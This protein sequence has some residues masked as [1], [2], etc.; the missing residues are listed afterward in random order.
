MRAVDILARKRD[1][2][3]LSPDEMKYLVDG[4][5][6]GQIPDYQ[7][8]AFLMAACVR[9]LTTA[10]TFSLTQAMIEN[11]AVIDLSAIEGIK[12]DKHSTGGVGDKVTLVLGPMLAAVGA[13]V[14]KM[15]GRALGNTGGTLDKLESIPGFSVNMDKEKFIKQINEIG[16]AI[17]GQ[18]DEVCKADKMI[19]ALRDV[20]ATVPCV[21]LI[22]SSIMS[23]KIASGADNIVI[24][25]KV[26]SG[27]FIK[28]LDDARKLAKELVAIGQKF[29]RKVVAVITNMDQPLGTT[30]GN[31]LEVEEAI[32]AM[33][34]F[35]SADLLEVCYTLGSNIM[36]K[37]GLAKNTEEAIK[38]LEDAVSSG[39][40]IE[41]FRQLVEAQ[42]GDVN[43]VEKPRETLPH[44]RFI[45][46]IEVMSDGFISRINAEEIGM[47]ARYLGAGRHKLG[48]KIDP[49]AGIIITH[50][51]GDYV[52]AGT[53]IAQT[54]SNDA[55]LLA[56]V[57]SL[58]EEAFQLTTVPHESPPLVY[59]IIE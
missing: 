39:K 56:V 19:Y 28:T 12:I 8:S 20:T 58:V 25:V 47:A 30:V 46:D 10:E 6:S 37:S 11:S 1:G 59:D 35:G 3:E 51:V 32:D 45:E 15:S 9:G 5:V 54:H 42:G 50:K 41:K 34:G 33:Q 52:R 36:V 55:H 21:G 27:A 40:V 57:R 48:D 24:D 53:A 29:G 23:K 43:V 44:S 18:T 14:A 16:I 49:G 17:V 38:K 26:G 4:F 13:K 31:T 2:L 22:A 7:M